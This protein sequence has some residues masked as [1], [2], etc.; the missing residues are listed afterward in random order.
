VATAETARER[1][2]ANLDL[3]IK[4]AGEAERQA[5]LYEAEAA[6]A[7]VEQQQVVVDELKDRLEEAEEE[8]DLRVNFQAAQCQFRAL[9]RQHE[10]AVAQYKAIL[11]GPLQEAVRLA[12]ADVE[13]AEKQLEEAR[14]NHSY[15]RVLAPISGVVLKVHRHVGDSVHTGAPTP[16]LSMADTDRLRIRLEVQ[17]VEAHDLDVGEEG[18]FSVRGRSG[19]AGRLEIERVLPMFDGR[20][21][22]DPNTAARLDTRVLPMLCEVTFCDED[23]ELRLNQRIT[24]EFVPDSSDSSAD[25]L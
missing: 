5:A 22:Y 16:V 14:K 6:R 8:G 21:Q 25:D 11:R 9:E 24:A 18:V 7:R 13:V 15:H 10:A 4:G 12:R 20:R 2:L 3:V 17:E 1:A 23:V 19:Q